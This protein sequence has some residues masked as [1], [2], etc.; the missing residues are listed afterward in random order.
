M[1]TPALCPGQRP[2]AI[3]FLTWYCPYWEMGIPSPHAIQ[4]KFRLCI[5]A[6]ARH[7][8]SG[9]LEKPAWL[10]Q[11]VFRRFCFAYLVVEEKVKV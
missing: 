6:A 11:N 10:R 8:I 5:F 3:S 4:Q 7:L 2:L 1:T 9:P